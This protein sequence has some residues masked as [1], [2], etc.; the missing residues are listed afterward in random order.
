MAIKVLMVGGRRCGKTSALASMFDQIKNGPVNKIFT[1][2]D[3]TVIE[4]KISP[5][6]GKEETKE[7]LEVKTLELK[8]RLDTPNTRTFLIDQ[9][10]TYN[11][12][13]YTLRLH[14]PGAPKRSTTIEFT[15]CPGEFFHPGLFKEHAKTLTQESDVFVIMVDTPYLMSASPT[16]NEAVN[17]TGT[18]PDILDQINKNKLQIVTIRNFLDR[19]FSDISCVSPGRAA[20]EYLTYGSRTVKTGAT[21]LSPSGTERLLALGT[22]VPNSPGK[23]NLHPA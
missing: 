14:V 5:I 23:K 22:T 16:M 7:A 2:I 4:K 12:W 10:P 8:G 21:V 3:D 1:I 15:D 17:C 18:I 20:F 19:S 13:T 11:D 9:A 6:T